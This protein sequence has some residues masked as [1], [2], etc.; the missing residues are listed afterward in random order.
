MTS[1]ELKSDILP[2]VY[3]WE[4]VRRDLMSTRNIIILLFGLV[5]IS[6]LI[7]ERF[8]DIEQKLNHIQKQLEPEKE[9]PSIRIQKN[10]IC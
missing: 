8:N 4:Y 1:Y 5:I 2:R 7:A 3:S 9:I 10:K 6:Y